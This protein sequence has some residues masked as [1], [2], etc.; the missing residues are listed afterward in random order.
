MADNAKRE[1]T[2]VDPVVKFEESD[3]IT[4]I[5]ASRGAETKYGVVF[6]LYMTNGEIDWPML[7]ERY[8]ME[9]IDFVSAGIRQISTRPNYDSAFV[10]GECDHQKLQDIADA[11][12]PGRR[13]VAAGPK[14][15]KETAKVA[16][17]V[18]KEIATAEGFDM[19]AFKEFMANRKK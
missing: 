7:K 1:I 16:R 11:Y 14:V 18:A 10:N 9:P 8:D 5:G 3:V 17:A 6:P 15:N 4:H 12:K 19:A 2:Y 13:A